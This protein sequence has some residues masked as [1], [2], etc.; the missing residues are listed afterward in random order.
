[1]LPK[2]NQD[3]IGD[4]LLRLAN[5]CIEKKEGVKLRRN[6]LRVLALKDPVDL[7]QKTELE[8]LLDSVLKVTYSY[9]SQSQ[10]WTNLRTPIEPNDDCIRIKVNPK[11][12]PIGKEDK[13]KVLVGVK[14]PVYITSKNLNF[15]MKGPHIGYQKFSS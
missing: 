9:I 14:V 6:F 13:V 11:Y 3:L 10:G 1:M 4:E 15:P 5:F 2:N 7:K 12:L 8:N